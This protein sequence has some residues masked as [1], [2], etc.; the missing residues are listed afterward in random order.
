M[1]FTLC[2]FA[3]EAGSGLQEQ[4]AALKENGIRL[5]EIRNVDG[6]NIADVSEAKAKEIKAALDKEGISVFSI[7][8]PIGKIKITDNFEE[9]KNTL[10]HILRL[11]KIFGCDKIRMFSFF[12]DEYKK[13]RAEIISR[14]NEMV[15]IA[16]EA[17]V[18]LYHENEKD[19]YGD[20]AERVLDILDNVKGLKSIY[21]PANY[22]QSGQDIT[23]A[24]N[25][26]FRRADYF[27]IKDVIKAT[28]ELVPAGEGDGQIK[29]MLGMIDGDA[30]LTVEPHLAVFD[31]YSKIDGR[32]MKNK[33]CFSSN[34]E[35]FDCAVNA[36][37]KIIS[38][39]GEQKK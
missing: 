28:G 11:C 10:R 34:R 38:N 20:L 35:A 19:I 14:L 4:I 16:G 6:Q 36:L 39:M 13:Y 25:T 31:G 30:V 37:K 7:G 27:H 29:K 2:A 5:L 12:T 24:L 9:H 32:E 21:D 23:A 17:G 15:K 22:I 1:K 18:T 8:S 33:Y 26:V 3:D